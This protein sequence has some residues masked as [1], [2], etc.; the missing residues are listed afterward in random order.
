MKR[1]A[2]KGEWVSSMSDP[3][4]SS[5]GRCERHPAGSSNMGLNN[6]VWNFC[7]DV[8][9]CTKTIWQSHGNKVKLMDG[10]GF[11]LIQTDK[12]RIDL[13][14]NA[15]LEKGNT[16]VLPASPFHMKC[17]ALQSTS[18]SQSPRSWSLSE[19]MPND[20]EAH[21]SWPGSLAATFHQNFLAFRVVFLNLDIIIMYVFLC[22]YF[23][24]RFVLICPR[25]NKLWDLQRKYTGTE[26]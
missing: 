3:L 26:N 1:R 19:R 4:T 20:D 18:F 5:S 15:S 24:T 14:L 22:V 9:I 16:V 11:S 17:R 6:N 23:G 21:T 7:D 13:Y 2:R 25:V 8:S 10:C 12:S